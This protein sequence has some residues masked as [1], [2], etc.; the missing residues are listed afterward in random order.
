V[1]NPNK[2]DK[3][4]QL[5]EQYPHAA[6]EIV[7]GDLKYKK[8]A[9]AVCEGCDLIIH[10]AAAMKG[11]AAEMFLDS[12]VASRNL[13][14]AV[15]AG[16]SVRVVL[17]SSFSAIGAAELPRG[18]VLDESS[19]LERHPEWR[20]VYSHAKLK[21]EQ[22]FWEYRERYGI[23]LTVLRPGVIY[24]PGGSPFSN[25]VGLP[26]FGLFFHL[27]GKN[28]LP[29]SYVENCAD[30]VTL[31]ALSP[32]AEGNI[33]HILDDDL[34]SSAQYLR[35]YSKH[36]KKMRCIRLPYPALMLISR[37]LAWYS[38]Y[39]KGQLPAVFT[40]YKTRTMWGGNRFSN[41]RLHSLGWTQRISTEEG[42]RRLFESLRQPV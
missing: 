26:L 12:V 38:R 40:P 29:L 31:A 21:Q 23:E 2:V 16:K 25:R 42:I 37:A 11:S 13:L 35:G 20:D 5:A 34:L 24:G 32:A 18:G 4:N 15:V 41:A 28:L 1:R 6:L 7:T 27:G 39:S 3:L 22:L 36:V 8:D 30:A 33:Y 17:I 10:A 19:P 9:S 14:D